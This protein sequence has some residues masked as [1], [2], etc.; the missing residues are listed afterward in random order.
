M[1]SQGQIIDQRIEAHR[2]GNH[3]RR[4]GRLS[5]SRE[6]AERMW[7]EIREISR[8]PIQPSER[9]PNS[10]LTFKGVELDYPPG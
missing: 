2:H 5:I 1:E 10:G 3:G 7:A 8:D 4:P 9:L 6:E